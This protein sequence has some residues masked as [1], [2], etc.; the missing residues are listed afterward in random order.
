MTMSRSGAAE[1]QQHNFSQFPPYS[2]HIHPHRPQDHQSGR[3]MNQNLFQQ[4]CLPCQP[5]VTLAV[6]NNSCVCLEEYLDNLSTWVYSVR[7]VMALLFIIVKYVGVVCRFVLD[8]WLTLS[9]SCS[10]PNSPPTLVPS[11]THKCIPLMPLTVK[12]YGWLNGASPPVPTA[13]SVQ[14]HTPTT[15]PCF[16][17]FTA[18]L[19]NIRRF[20]SSPIRALLAWYD[21][22][23]PDVHRY[24]GTALSAASLLTGFASSP[25]APDGRFSAAQKH[26]LHAAL[27]GV[28]VI[29][30]RAWAR[31][32][33][34]LTGDELMVDA[35]CVVCCTE[36]VD[37]LLMPCRH[38]V[39]CEVSGGFAVRVGGA[40]EEGRC[41]VGGCAGAKTLLGAR[42]V[43]RRWKRWCVLL[44]CELGG[45]LMGCVDQ[46]VSAVI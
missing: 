20:L 13:A 16:S 12:I 27:V 37:V 1:P 45:V 18:T 24:S 5:V 22:P 34:P 14:P 41:V 9:A 40:D 17:R 8:I 30:A 25:L 35:G 38:M 32:G 43:E 10:A 28:L 2:L 29:R 44:S 6:A 26:T 23:Q 3:N 7:W 4:S 21:S 31:D 42:F 36:I 11:L 19:H 46:G 33:L 15:I 39:V